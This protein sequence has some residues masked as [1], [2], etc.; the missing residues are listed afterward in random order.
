MRLVEWK[1]MA[2]PSSTSLFMELQRF[3]LFSQ[4]N[5]LDIVFFSFDS[6]EGSL[7][8]DWGEAQASNDFPTAILQFP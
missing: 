3:Q 8:F 2:I 1:C 4:H 7:T 6:N 5:P